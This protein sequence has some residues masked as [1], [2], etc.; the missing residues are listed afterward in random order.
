MKSIWKR[1]QY[2]GIGFGIGLIFVG[3][4]FQNRG[5][6]WLPSNRVKN[7]LM[8]KVLVLPESQEEIMRK[9]RLTEEELIQFLNDGDVVFNASIKEPAVFP[10]AYVLEREIAGKMHRVQFSIYED[11]YI[12]PV[13]YVEENGEAVNYENLAGSGRFLR[14]PKDSALVFIDKSDYVQ[15]KS[16]GLADA[17]QKSIVEALANSGSIDFDK[18]DLMLPK[19]EHH[20][21]FIQSNG[22]TV[23]AKTI[24]FESRITFKD[25]YWSK[26]LPCEKNG[27]DK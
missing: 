8:D 12:T 13:H 10:K 6:S 27:N 1:F 3:F 9:H 11:S 5:C 18:S 4:F 25:F 24:W 15:C 16:T 20:I 14:L 17:E 2:Y 7:T 19:A 23:Q 21:S 22:D 26:P